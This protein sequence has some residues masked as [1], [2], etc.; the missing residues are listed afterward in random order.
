MRPEDAF[1][2]GPV[3][4]AIVR[5]RPEVGQRLPTV[6]QFTGGA[7]NRSY[8]LDYG[9][10]SLVLRRPPAGHVTGNAHDMSR[11]FRVLSALAP[12]YP[13]APRAILLEEDT[14]IMGEPFLVME[15]IPG[16]ILRKDPPEDLELPSE[17]CHQLCE[18]F[19]DGLVELHRLSVAKTPLEGFGSGEGYLHRQ[20]QGWA[21]RYRSARTPDAASFEGVI[22]WLEEHTPPQVSRV[23]VH[24]DYRFDNLILDRNQ[25]SK[26]VG[27]LDW[28]LSTLGDPLMDLGNSLAYW[29]QADDDP[30][31]HM[32]RRQPTH[33]TG[34]WRRAEVVDAYLEKMDLAVNDLRFYEVMG[35][36]R[37]AGIAQQIYRRYHDGLTTNPAFRDFI[38][39][40]NYFEQRISGL[41]DP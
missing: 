2:P 30:M 25:P 7:S 33:L 35:L 31:M 23:W 14:R 19:V 27:V 12:L 28:E 4:E 9:H 20:V 13:K 40:V 11:E 10:Q 17:A 38:H 26:V 22:Q 36:F 39:G 6:T 29:V 37:L 16:I 5:V 34:M 15:E 24:N 21:K 3:H 18:T 1:D 8:R 41:I 32:I